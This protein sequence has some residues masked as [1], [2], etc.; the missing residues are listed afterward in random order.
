[1]CILTF[2][3]FSYL[4]WV[5]IQINKKQGQ[6]EEMTAIYQMKCASEEITTN[7]LPLKCLYSIYY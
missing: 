4:P 7:I 6:K 5:I 1:M 3:N 2:T